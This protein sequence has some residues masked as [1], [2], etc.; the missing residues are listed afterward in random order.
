M[1]S[2][3]AIGGFFGL[4]LRPGE[5]PHQDA[6]LLASGRNC[7][8]YI[9]LAAKFTHV[10]LPKFTCDA[11]IE[12]LTKLNIPHT[13]YSLTD[14]LELESELTLG[15]GE[16]LIYNNYFGLKSGYSEKLSGKYGGQLILD[17]SQAFFA[18]PPAGSHTFYSPR[19]FFGLPDGGCLYTPARL[20]EE[21]PVATSYERSAHLLKRIDLGPDEAYPDF[22]ANERRLSG[23]P[24][25]QM[26]ALTRG[27]L[28][29]LDFEV[30]R[31]SRR[32]NFAILDQKLKPTNR[33]ALELADGDVPLAYPYLVE[34]DA[35][36]PRL[37]ERRVFVPQ[38][39]PNVLD[40]SEDTDLEHQLAANLLPLP[41][42]QRY[43]RP[44]MER[45]LGVLDESQHQSAQRIRRLHL[46][47]V[48]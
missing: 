44:E 42:D 20:Q 47:K 27:L 22:Q 32:D 25:E 18:H 48:A 34:N 5:F 17:Y 19:K 41:I 37:I 38:Y 33:L 1:N 24:I 35:L 23:R 14:M 9:L 2:Y 16:C 40:W 6:I 43:G 3:S 4:E 31:Q 29:G 8:E 46:G 13:F 39:W 30:A 10:Y 7:F 45:I 26:S 28:V 21:F 12:P 36:R 11:M 15:E